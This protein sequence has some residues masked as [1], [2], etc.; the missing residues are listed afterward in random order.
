MPIHTPLAS[1]EP[2][3]RELLAQL[4]GQFPG[5][6]EKDALRFLVARNFDVSKAAPFLE[7][8][9][10]WRKSYAPSEVTQ[11]SVPRVLPSGHWR[12]LGTM[13]VEGV[14]VAVIWVQVSLFWPGQYDVPEFHALLV[15]FL[16]RLGQV[17]EQFVFLFD[18]AGWRISHGLHLRKVHAHITTL[19]EHYPERLRAALLVGVP[20]I[21]FA[22]W[23]LIRLMLDPVTASKVFFLR[24]GESQAA[25]LLEHI[26]KSVLPVRYG[27]E[28]RDEDTP[29]PGELFLTANPNPN[30]NH[31]H[32]HNHNP[33]PN[34]DPDP[35]PDP[36]PN[37]NPNPNPSPDHSSASTSKGGNASVEASR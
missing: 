15:Y 3:E 8:D 6:P 4:C 31:N 20:A 9:L 11:A 7:A 24:G 1:L 32:N 35:D 27:G 17:A 2:A 19:Q 26:D 22:S 25:E 5:V 37:P 12:S 30:H 23:K 36:D 18:M 10:A 14:S 33:D 13:Q 29:V 34:P 16:E 21:F 28:R